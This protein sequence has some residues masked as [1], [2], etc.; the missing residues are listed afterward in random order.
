MSKLFVLATI[1]AAALW[2]LLVWAAGSVL[3]SS[4]EFLSSQAAAWRFHEPEAELALAAATAA[5]SQWGSA[6]LWVVWGAGILGLVVCASVS[7][8]IYR[9]LRSLFGRWWPGPESAPQA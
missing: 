3:E 6:L 7:A 2:S 1:S 8:M 4:A 9:A 5:F